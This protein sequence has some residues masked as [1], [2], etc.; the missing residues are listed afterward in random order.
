ML[1]WLFQHKIDIIRKKCAKKRV[2]L[3]QRYVNS[4]RNVTGA[5]TGGGRF[6]DGIN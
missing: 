5:N 4:T 3:G 2:A 1:Q 6:I